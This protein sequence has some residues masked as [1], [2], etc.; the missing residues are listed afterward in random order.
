MECSDLAS[1]LNS[2]SS[3]CRFI[4]NKISPST[5]G[6]DSLARVQ[7]SLS[8]AFGQP[9]LYKNFWFGAGNNGR[10]PTILFGYI[11]K[12]HLGDTTSG[13]VMRVFEVLAKQ[14]PLLSLGPSNNSS[15]GDHEKLSKVM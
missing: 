2:G 11:P 15:K 6:N 14:D 13:C 3:Q 10:S 9:H 1:A 4:A 5:E 12:S 7:N 8:V